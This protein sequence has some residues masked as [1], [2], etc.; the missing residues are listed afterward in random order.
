MRLVN[1][2]ALAV[3]TIWQEARNQTEAGK[4]AVAEVIR[5]RMAK[6]YWSDG[7]VAG[8]VLRPYQFSGWNTEDPNRI[9]SFRLEDGD[10][11]VASCRAAWELAKAGSRTVGDAVLYLNPAAVVRIPDWVSRSKL[12]ARVGAHSFYVPLA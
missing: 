8:T 6:R 5:N 7:T 2:D 9:P 10:P 12:V 11:I 3:I 1:D 4:L